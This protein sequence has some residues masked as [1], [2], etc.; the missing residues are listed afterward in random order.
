MMK[1]YILYLSSNKKIQVM[2]ILH[3]IQQIKIERAEGRDQYC[4][5]SNSRGY[6]LLN[7]K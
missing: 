4:R 2:C 6:V 7:V 3:A 1:K 5:S